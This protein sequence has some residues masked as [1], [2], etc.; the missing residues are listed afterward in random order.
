MGS[1]IDRSAGVWD[2]ADDGVEYLSRAEE[3]G[4]RWP[5]PGDLEEAALEKLLFPR[6]PLLSPVRAQPDWAMIHKEL[7][8]KE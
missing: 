2:W 4:L 8:R 3:V 5:L 6:G 7:R 1:A